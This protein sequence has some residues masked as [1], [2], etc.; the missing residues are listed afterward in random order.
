MHNACI[1]FIIIISVTQLL[2]CNFIDCNCTVSSPASCNHL[3][4]STDVLFYAVIQTNLP[5]IELV[6]LHTL[7]HDVC[8]DTLFVQELNNSIDIRTL[9]YAWMPI[10]L[11]HAHSSSHQ[12]IRTYSKYVE[13]VTKVERSQWLLCIH[14][15]ARR[16]F[17]M[18]SYVQ[19][20]S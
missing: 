19:R 15:I 16:R 18:L 7:G 11:A 20:H 12:Y 4:A 5:I 10:H 8:N 1:Q 14:P 13:W 17:S 3:I 6:P 2:V 9:I